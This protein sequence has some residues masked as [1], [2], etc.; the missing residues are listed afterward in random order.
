MRKLPNYLN[1]PIPQVPNYLH[2]PITKL[3]QLS[4]EIAQ[5]PNCRLLIADCQLTTPPFEEYNAD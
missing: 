4:L 5:P 1:Y 2:S 3:L